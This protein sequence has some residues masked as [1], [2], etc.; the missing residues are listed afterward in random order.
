VT[1]A[2]HFRLDGSNPIQ[3]HQ[4]RQAKQP[5]QDPAQYR[6]QLLLALPAGHMI[7]AIHLEA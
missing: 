2:H 7:A 1:A 6:Q 5:W 4:Q 3:R